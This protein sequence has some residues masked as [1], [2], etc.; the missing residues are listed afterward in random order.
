MKRGSQ[1]VVHSDLR[2]GTYDPIPST[3]NVHIPAVPT[4]KLHSIAAFK[5]KA[6]VRSVKEQQKREEEYNKALG[7]SRTAGTSH[8]D[9]TGVPL[10]VNTATLG[11]GRGRK[12]KISI[13]ASTSAADAMAMDTGI[14]EPLVSMVRKESLM[15]F[16][17]TPEEL[18]H[19]TESL[20]ANMQICKQQ[21]SALE[22][23]RTNL[24]WLL[25]RS[26]A[27][28]TQRNHSAEPATVANFHPK[29]RLRGL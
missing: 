8:E 14:P 17:Q 10:V 9:A 18:K 28:E 11:V 12:S 4:W 3:Y 27:F 20:N 7:V 16:S 21:M 13:I 6:F 15:Q 29:K 22:R 2:H 26:T 5:K 1:G 23:I 25:D 19:T 24:T